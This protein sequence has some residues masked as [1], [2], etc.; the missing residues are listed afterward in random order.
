MPRPHGCGGAAD[1][2]A[3][4][5]AGAPDRRRRD[6][7][8]RGRGHRARRP[9]RQRTPPL[10]A[11]A[12]RRLRRR[13][14]DAADGELGEFF[15]LGERGNFSQSAHLARALARAFSQ[16]CARQAFPADGRDQR[17]RSERHR[18]AEPCRR[19]RQGPEDRQDRRGPGPGG[20][21]DHRT[22]MGAL[23]QARQLRDHRAVVV[24]GVSA[25]VHPH[26][27]A[28]R[29]GIDPAP[30]RQALRAARLL[31]AISR[32]GPARRAALRGPGERQH[33]AHGHR[34]EPRGPAGGVSRTR[35]S[36]RRF[37]RSQP[38]HDAAR[39]HSGWRDYS[40]LCRRS[41]GADSRRAVDARGHA[42]AQ[43]ARRGRGG[44]GHR[45]PRRCLEDG[46]LRV[47]GRQP[48]STGRQR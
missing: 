15:A 42:A 11:E 13:A 48:R 39:A 7:R 12:C 27:G 22:G 41:P 46:F 18:P 1:G 3:P 31:P 32:R 2:R 43:H 20:E 37:P 16:R 35:S 40:R 19:L 24:R 9:G 28:R 10:G 44:G 34:A 23:G 14:T 5:V 33:R 26:A 30:D 25:V 21:R 17:R 38:R 4:R 8:A 29:R 45:L 47:P 36:P 6:D